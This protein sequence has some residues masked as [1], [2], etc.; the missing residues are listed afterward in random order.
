MIQGIE[1]DYV[2]IPN[3]IIANNKSNDKIVAKIV[4]DLAPIYLEYAMK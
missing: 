4:G 1:D 2:L 3:N